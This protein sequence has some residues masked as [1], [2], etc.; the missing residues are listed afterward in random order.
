MLAPIRERVEELA[1]KTYG[2]DPETDLAI[3][4]VT[5]PARSASFLIADGVV[6]ANEGR[7]YVLRRVIRRGIR[8]A[9]RLGIEDASLSRVGVPVIDPL[10]PRSIRS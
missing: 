8:F 10:Q 7:G 9:R 2:E 4:V 5:E 6:P 3:R 1:V